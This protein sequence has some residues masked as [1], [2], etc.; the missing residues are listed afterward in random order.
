M[1]RALLR[2]INRVF[3]S[4]PYRRTFILRIP[5]YC[6]LFNRGQV[7]NDAAGAGSSFQRLHLAEKRKKESVPLVPASAMVT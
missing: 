1:C 6:T 5:K 2:H 7:V 4:L 3:G